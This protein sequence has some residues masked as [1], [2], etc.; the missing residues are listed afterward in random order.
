MRSHEV[1]LRI[2]LAPALPPVLRIGSSY[3]K[4]SSTFVMNG[5]EAM[6]SVDGGHASW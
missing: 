4:G 2:E 3:S 1:S 5:I 6:A